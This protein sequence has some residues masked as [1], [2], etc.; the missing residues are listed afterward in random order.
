GHGIAGEH[1]RLR[2]GVERCKVE[3]QLFRQRLVD[4]QEPRRANGCGLS[5]DVEARQ[6]AGERIVERKCGRGRRFEG[7]IAGHAWHFIA[8]VEIAGSH[9][10]GGA[11]LTDIRDFLQEAFSICCRA[12]AGRRAEP[13]WEGHMELPRRTFLRLTASAAALPFTTYLVGAQSLHPPPASAAR[14]LPLAN[15]LADYTHGVR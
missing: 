5:R 11:P 13:L 6:L 9:K 1:R 14:E 4:E 10:K 3:A 15:P 7:R 8:A 12:T 2:R